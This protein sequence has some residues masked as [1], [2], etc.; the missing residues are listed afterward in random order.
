M[1]THELTGVVGDI[2]VLVGELSRFGC[3]IEITEWVDGGSAARL[4]AHL[5][6]DQE[7]ADK[8]RRLIEERKGPVVGP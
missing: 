6:D 2:S 3:S 4:E 8:C 1:G 5:P 7:L